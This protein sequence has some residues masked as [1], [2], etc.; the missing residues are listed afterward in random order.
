MIEN[1]KLES[2]IALKPDVVLGYHF[3]GIENQLKISKNG[4]QVI[5]INEYL[6]SSP[7][8]YVDG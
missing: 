7:L 2:I 6:E 1:I 5:Y 8:A 4:T 3:P